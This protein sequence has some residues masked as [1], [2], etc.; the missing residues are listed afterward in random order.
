MISNNLTLMT[1]II[2]TG[3]L[4]AGGTYYVTTHSQPSD[5]TAEAEQMVKLSPAKPE[6]LTVAA[7][8][9]P[10]QPV[11]ITIKTEVVEKQRGRRHDFIAENE[12]ALRRSQPRFGI[13]QGK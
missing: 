4:T 6:P 3:A 10:S 12:A 7:A 9:A 11:E 13:F 5:N 1:S 2:L 8:Q